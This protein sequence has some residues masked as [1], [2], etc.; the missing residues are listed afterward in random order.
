MRSIINLIAVTLLTLSSFGALA[1]QRA[2][3][4]PENPCRF[5]LSKV[6]D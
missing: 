2:L 3:V 1:E 6:F 4:G 5:I